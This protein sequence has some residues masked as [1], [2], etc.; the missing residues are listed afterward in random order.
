MGYLTGSIVSYV[1]ANLVAKIIYVWKCLPESLLGILKALL[2]WSPASLTVYDRRSAEMGFRAGQIGLPWDYSNLILNPLLVFFTFF[3]IS[4]SSWTECAGLVVWTLFFYGWSRFMH[5]RV[6]SIAFYSTDKL[7]R[8][9]WMIWGAAPLALVATSAIAWQFRAGVLEDAPLW[10]K[11]ALLLFTYVFCSLL[12]VVTLRKMYPNTTEKGPDAR[13][14][15]FLNCK[16]DWIFSW[17]NCNPVFTVKCLHYLPKLLEDTELGKVETQVVGKAA[18]WDHPLACGDDPNEVRYYSPGK[19]YLHFSPE[20]QKK[21]QEGDF[22]DWLEFESYL[23]ALGHMAD[24]CRRK[25]GRVKPE[26]L[27][28]QLELYKID[29]NA[30]RI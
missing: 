24:L 21:M 22:H 29:F 16:K 27:Y 5:L 10:Q 4:M 1:Q 18:M 7:D 28:K 30:P 25:R 8:N 15:D 6:Q 11:W 19:E 17:F 14:G 13:D 20:K 26:E 9:V 12:W 3:V 23:E 2:P